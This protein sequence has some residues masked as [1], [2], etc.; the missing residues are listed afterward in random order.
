MAP[1]PVSPHASRLL[2]GGMI[3]RSEDELADSKTCRR[4]LRCDSVNG[5]SHI[6]VFM[7]GARITGLWKSHARTT[8]VLTDVCEMRE[9]CSIGRILITSKLSEAPWAIL[10]SE[11]AESGAITRTS[12]HL[13]S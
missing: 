7:A 9:R 10:E 8:H 13:R 3:V 6:S 4:A 11:L 2:M 12:A 1:T 5:F